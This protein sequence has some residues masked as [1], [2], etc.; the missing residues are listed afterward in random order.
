MT[1]VFISHS[2]EDNYFVDFLVELLKFHH[3][4]VWVDSSNLKG[5]SVFTAEIEQALANCDLML[6]VTSHDSLKSKWITREISAFKAI[7]GDR[8]VIPLVLDKGADPN[9]IYEGLGAV[10]QLRCHESMLGS[11]R[12]LLLLLGSTLFPVVENRKQTDRRSGERRVDGSDRR[13]SS[14][15]QRL[16]VGMYKL[17]IGEGERERKLLQPMRGMSEVGDLAGRLAAPDSPLHAFDFVDRETGGQV[18]LTYRMI[19]EMV[20]TS[21]Q[22]RQRTDQA[23]AAYVIDD[24]VNDIVSAYTVRSKDRRSGTRRSGNPRRK[25]EQ[26]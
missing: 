1:Y 9:E 22:A 7:G 2:S 8:S 20:F 11:L 19:E 3:V 21:W 12:E 23:G 4:D 16:R 13:K 10:T 5:G 14:V 18:E 17:V 6:V 15:Q 25:G 26:A 24:V